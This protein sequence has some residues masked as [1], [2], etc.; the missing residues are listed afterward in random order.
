[1]GVLIDWGG[2]GCIFESYPRA[3][4]LCFISCPVAA[5]FGQRNRRW[6]VP[7]G[8]LV[9]RT[10]RSVYHIGECGIRAGLAAH[11]AVGKR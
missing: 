6:L 9:E 2:G 3:K 5:A 4:K 10:E 7:L 11:N 1:M 8:N